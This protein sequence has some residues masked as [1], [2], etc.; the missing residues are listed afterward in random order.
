MMVKPE[1]VARAI[2]FLASH[3][4]AGH[5]TGECIGGDGGMDGW[6]MIDGVMSTTASSHHNLADSKEIEDPMQVIPK[7][8]PKPMRTK[9]RVAISIDMD[10]VSGWLG[11]GNISLQI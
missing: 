4:A 10:A 9:V 7:A 2:T 11:R 1:D 8:M 3:R 6:S 5:I